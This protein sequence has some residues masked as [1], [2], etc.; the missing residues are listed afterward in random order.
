VQHGARV[1]VVALDPGADAIRPVSDARAE[2]SQ[3]GDDTSGCTAM[4][5][6]VSTTPP[7]Q[8]GQCAPHMMQ[9]RFS[10]VS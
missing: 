4:K 8:K 5:N 2:D 1:L 9:L 10:S 3:L 6:P 7:L